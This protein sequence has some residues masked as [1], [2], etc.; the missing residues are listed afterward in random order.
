MDFSCKEGLL[1]IV[2]DDSDD[3]VII[4]EEH[5][6]LMIVHAESDAEES[7]QESMSYYLQFSVDMVPDSV[8]RR[9]F[10]ENQWKMKP[11]EEESSSLSILPFDEIQEILVVQRSDGPLFC[12]EDLYEK[13][14]SSECRWERFINVAQFDSEK[15]EK[16]TNF[17]TKFI[18]RM[19][20]LL[21]CREQD[22]SKFSL[23]RVEN[24]GSMKRFRDRLINARIKAQNRR[25]LSILTK[26]PTTSKDN[27][28]LNT[29]RF[30]KIF[31]T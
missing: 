9:N 31:L 3:D 17:E 21:K 23:I 30:P 6:P 26:N 20:P 14:F 15:I 12:L 27:S 13:A 28:K 24:Y 10:N 7:F 8:I 29:N 4:L 2:E 18:R 11:N 22:D 1:G 25:W 19:F 5:Q 16:T